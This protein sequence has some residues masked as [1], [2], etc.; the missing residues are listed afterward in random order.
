MQDLNFKAPSFE[1]ASQFVQIEEIL[2]KAFGFEE[3]FYCFL[4]VLHSFRSVL[5]YDE[6]IRARIIEIQRRSP[7]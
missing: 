1:L 2:K 7:S 3:I 4:E 5:Y 6:F